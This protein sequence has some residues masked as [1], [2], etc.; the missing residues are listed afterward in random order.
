[1][2]VQCVMGAAAGFGLFQTYRFVFTGR[3]RTWLA[4]FSARL[5][6]RVLIH[7]G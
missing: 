1:M 2:C 7:P 3:A 5:R 4:E 6:A